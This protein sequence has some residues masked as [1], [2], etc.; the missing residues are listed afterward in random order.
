MIEKF[1]THYLQR[2]P[3]DLIYMIIDIAGR[4]YPGA[5]EVEPSYLESF[6]EHHDRSVREMARK[7]LAPDYNLYVLQYERVI[8]SLLRGWYRGFSDCYNK[9]G[10]FRQKGA[11]PGF[12]LS[13]RFSNLHLFTEL[14]NDLPITKISLR[15]FGDYVCEVTDDEE[16]VPKS[17]RFL[18]TEMYTLKDEDLK[19]MAALRSVEEISF[20]NIALE[21]ASSISRFNDFLNN[22]RLRK[23]DFAEC[24]VANWSKISW[25][26]A[27]SELNSETLIKGKTISLPPSVEKFSFQDPDFD[28]LESYNLRHPVGATLKKLHLLSDKSGPLKLDCLPPSLDYLKV[29]FPI[30]EFQGLSWPQKLLRISICRCEIDDDFLDEM[31]AIQWPSQLQTL[32]FWD[33][34]FHFLSG[35]LNTLPD[36]LQKLELIDQPLLSLESFLTDEPAFFSF[37]ANL[38]HLAISGVKGRIQMILGKRLILPKDLKYLQISSCT[39]PHLDFLVIPPSIVEM[40]FTS[41]GIQ[42]LE[43]YDSGSSNITTK[44]TLLVNLRKLT[45]FCYLSMSL[46]NW[47][48][49]PSLQELH[50]RK[51]KLSSLPAA[52]LYSLHLLHTK[53]TKEFLEREVILPPN[54]QSWHCDI[55]VKDFV[56]PLSVCNHKRLRT[57]VL[58]GDDF[59][60]VNRM[61]FPPHVQGNLAL[62]RLKLKSFL[63]YRPTSEISNV[64]ALQTQQFYDDMERAF[65]RVVV[66]RPESV[67][68]NHVL[69]EIPYNKRRKVLSGK[70]VAV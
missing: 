15:I 26:P 12:E 53:L 22:S 4:E 52:P 59:D 66:S 40:S 61:H 25:P 23:L 6:L 67:I 17:H 42:N 27:M 31:E 48:P 10:E 47:R 69:E 19:R 29:E 36:S 37:P 55:R 56:V 70:L 16:V 58:T 18:E 51:I 60:Y 44:W 1:L 45:F 24:S 21:D 7:C 43:S 41:C 13:V 34:D 49:P 20:N 3:D 63:L 65:G 2:L 39:I 38:K 33:N 32:K 5:R 57:W 14:I 9:L 30:T 35:A 68:N 50:L 28:C 54:L 11:M 46:E 64:T 62:Q 8:L